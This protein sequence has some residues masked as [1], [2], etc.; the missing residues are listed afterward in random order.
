MNFDSCFADVELG[1][2]FL[3]LIVACDAGAEFG[4][5]RCQSF[6]SGDECATPR[7]DLKLLGI[8]AECRLDDTNE[9]VEGYGFEEEVE[10]SIL[11]GSNRLGRRALATNED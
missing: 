3:D 7:S 11:H 9:L 8:P 2:D 1:C 10:G 5:A 6:Q 4:L